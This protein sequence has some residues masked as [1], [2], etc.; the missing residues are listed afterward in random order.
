MT[1][2]WCPPATKTFD[3]EKSAATPNTLPV[4]QICTTPSSAPL[5][6]PL[7]NTVSRFPS[8]PLRV[9]A[10]LSRP[11]TSSQR[12]SP[13]CTRRLSAPL[14]PLPPATH[15]F[16]QKHHASATLRATMSVYFC[17]RLCRVD[18][19]FKGCLMVPSSAG[20]QLQRKRRCHC[21]NFC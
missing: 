16:N 13:F 21:F 19:K 8:K 15:R 17:Y 10:S 20:L 7:F 11:L 3:P 9:T 1:R 5:A 6:F 12:P 4:P 18:S 14:P 2:V